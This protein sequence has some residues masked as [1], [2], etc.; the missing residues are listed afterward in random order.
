MSQHFRTTALTQCAPP[1]VVVACVSCSRQ[2]LRKGIDVGF[3]PITPRPKRL[4]DQ[5]MP[6][7]EDEVERRCR[8][9]AQDE[10]HVAASFRG[11]SKHGTNIR[12]RLR[13]QLRRQLHGKDVTGFGRISVR[14]VDEGGSP[15]PII[16]STSMSA[17]LRH[18]QFG[19]VPRGDSYY[20][21][22]FSETLAFGVVP[23]I[24]SD[25]WALPFE[26]IID[27]SKASLRV[28]ETE[29]HRL[30][31]LLAKLSLDQVCELRRRVFTI[32]HRYLAGPEQW[33]RA[34]EE[35]FATRNHGIHSL[36]PER[37]KGQQL[38]SSSYELA[39]Q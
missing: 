5:G 9:H 7:S 13:S 1:H 39:V 19:L 10:Q 35:I 11:G 23:V 33:N 6:T 8:T 25:D 24:I 16:N 32:Y 22:R 17:D 30:P 15:P 31:G 38:N 37:L 14:L 28:A 26:E 2:H 12:K 21:Y 3:P 18:S 4:A 27:W 20:S 36:V 34:L 29:L